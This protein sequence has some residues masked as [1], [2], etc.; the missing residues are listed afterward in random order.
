MN[1][2]IFRIKDITRRLFLRIAGSALFMAALPASVHAFFVKTLGVRTVEKEKFK[3]NADKG[4]IEWETG[5]KEEY[6]LTVNGLV[7]K[8]IT[9]SYG[10]ITAIP[11]VEQISDFHCVEGWSVMDLK[12]RGFRFREILKRVEPDS[13]ADHILFHSFGRTGYIPDH[14]S[15]YIESFPIKDLLDPKQEILLVLTMDGKPLPEEHGGPL[16]V[17][18]PYELAYKSIKFVAG[19]EFIK[20]AR[21]GWWT[22]A[23][24]VYTIDAPV[25]ADRL[26]KRS[27]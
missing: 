9:L 7:K 19:I 14:Q 18:A 24:P 11:Q 25:P 26:R 6:K 15:H 21:P 2:A 12:W 3:F 23:N 22:L 1:S 16:R 20:G 5:A 13:N 10:E 8:P 17:I 27:E 4:L